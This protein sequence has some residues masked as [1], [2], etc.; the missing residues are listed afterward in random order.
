MQTELFYDDEFQALQM[1]VANGQKT[2]KQLAAHLFPHLKPDSAYARLKACFNPDRDERLTF[3]QIV[4]AMKFC[5]AYDP[6]YFVADETEHARPERRAPK[7]EEA[8]LLRV[9]NGAAA[10][11]ER[12]MARLDRLR[13]MP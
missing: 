3:G 7:D 9:L 10:T 2:T 13:G 12:A 8:N 1:M 6:L 5:D 4:A 11:M